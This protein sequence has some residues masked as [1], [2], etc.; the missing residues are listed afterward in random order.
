MAEY[1]QAK[2]TVIVNL[3][4]PEPS[5]FTVL[6]EKAREKVCE[7]MRKEI[8]KNGYAY[9]IEH[10]QYKRVSDGKLVE[11]ERMLF[12]DSKGEPVMKSNGLPRAL[13]GTKQSFSVFDAGLCFEPAQEQ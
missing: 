4:V 7:I 8:E 6:G 3:A 1:I 2:R 5:D 11:A 12:L 10:G 13:T 9:R